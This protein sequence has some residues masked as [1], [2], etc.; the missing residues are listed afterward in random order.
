VITN[1]LPEVT[2]EL[3]PELDAAARKV[4]K[5]DARAEASVGFG[6][7]TEG[8]AITRTYLNQVTSAVIQKLSGPRPKSDAAEFKLERLLR[9]LDP[10]V[11]ALC[12]LQCGLHCAGRD[13]ASVVSVADT[14][15]EG[16]N[17][18]LWAQGLL[19]TDAKLAHRIAKQ[20]EARFPTV[21]MRRAYAKRLAEEEGFSMESWPS[22]LCVRAGNWGMDVLL[23]ALPLV[24]QREEPRVFM[25]PAIWSITEFGLDMAKAALAETVCMN[26]VYQPRTERPKDWDAF[27]MRVAEDD[28]TMDRKQIIRTRHPDNIAKAKHAIRTGQM[29]PAL[30]ALNVM[31]SVPFKINTW[32]LDVMVDCYNKG[33]AV[34]GLPM[35]G[36]LEVPPK[37]TP[38]QWEAMS[39]E[40]RK[41]LSKTRKGRMKANRA[42]DAAVISFEEDL[43]ICERIALADQFFT[44]MNMDW[45]SRVY[46]LTHFSFQREDRVRALFLFANGEPIG[47]DGIRWL[48]IHVANC[49]AF[50]KVDKKTFDERIKWVD[51]NLT[52][53]ADYVRRPLFSTGWTKADAPFLFL[54]ACREL[55]CAIQTGPSYVCHL[56]TSWDGSCNGLQHLCLMTRA[57]EGRY[58]NLTATEIPEDVYQR[59]ADLAKKLIEADLT[60]D[61]LFYE[62]TED[63]KRKINAPIKVLARIALDYGVD[64]K[65]VKRNTM[66]F[67]YS[68]NEYGMS[69]QHFEDTMEPLELKLL[70]GEIETHPFGE[71]P[72]EWRLACKYLAKRVYEAIKAVVTLP[73]EAMA[74]M[75]TLA[76]QLA[77]EGKPLRWTTPAGVPCINRYHEEETERLKLFCCSNGVRTRND[78]TVA[79]GY[80]KPIDKKKSAAGIAANLTHSQDAS[81]LLLTVAAAASE[82]ITDIATVH[83]SFGCLPSRAGRLNEILR[84]QFL[85]MY[86]DHDILTELLESAK[87]DLDNPD[88]LPELPAKGS[89]NLKEILNARYAF[90]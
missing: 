47:E 5:R 84:E 57:P 62:E 23:T 73:A 34:D 70:K 24:F 33:I 60:N 22:K 7:T 51:D 19:L 75:Q 53:I 59:V 28:R 86:T 4:A 90:A 26:P 45:R 13:G 20:A 58:V 52:L 87:R 55:I 32:V 41:L 8:M 88:K 3:H 1:V 48:K 80:K 18:E 69:A 44:P 89:L 30:T 83:D 49:G 50:D 27:V 74:F 71:S 9:K 14:M 63:K 17:D 35:W 72:L 29:A 42:N 61:D 37:A 79:V 31:Q 10:Q 67:S 39:V 82:G 77:H 25:G 64:R 21:S 2:P 76:K 12:I 6:A 38:E 36:K 43:M 54:A 81:H 46:S 15:G 68:S 65:L 40:K 78:L 11:L 56:P 16:I 66:T 85:K